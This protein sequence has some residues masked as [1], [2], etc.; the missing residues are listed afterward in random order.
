MSSISSVISAT[1]TGQGFNPMQAANP[2][3]DLQAIGSALKS[4]D[5]STA[6]SALATFQQALATAVQ[7][8][9]G[10]SQ[11]LLTQPFG[12]NTQANTDYQSLVNALKSGDAASAQKAFSSLQTDIKAAWSA[13]KAYHAHHQH[14]RAGSSMV[15]AASSAKAGAIGVAGYCGAIASGGLNATA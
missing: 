8:T 14:H 1:N 4:G 7:G 9:P 15:A 3:Q 12:K 2:I 5:L 13:Q 6:K 11:T 10:N